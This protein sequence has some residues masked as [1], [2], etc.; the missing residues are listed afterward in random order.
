MAKIK[1]TPTQLPKVSKYARDRQRPS[2]GYFSIEKTTVEVRVDDLIFS[3]NDPRSEDQDNELVDE[4]YNNLLEGGYDEDGQLPAVVVNEYGT[5]DII[6]HH[7]LISALKRLKQERWYVD[8]YEYTGIDPEY[9]WVAA[10]D[11]GFLINNLKNPQKKTTM[12][13]VVRAAQDRIKKYGY[14]YRPG[15]P[16]DEPHI[17]MWLRETKQHEVFSEGKLTLITNDILKPGKYA[18]KKIRNLS[19]DEVREMI[20]AR[21]KNQYGTGLLNDGRYGYVV[22]TDTAKADAPKWW[23]QV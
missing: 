5:Y 6:D 11:F 14:V 20:C 22:C 21:T 2:S 4:I 17:R 7:H 3:D 19:T 13:S 16:I 10:T 18:G 8:V 1:F 9:M 12:R 15:T 23:N